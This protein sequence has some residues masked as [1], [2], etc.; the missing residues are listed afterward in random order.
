MMSDVMS[1]LW[2]N[3]FFGPV[4]QLIVQ[5]RVEEILSLDT[6]ALVHEN[7]ILQCRDR[8]FKL[9]TGKKIKKKRVKYDF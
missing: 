8:V 5:G 1:L 9:V 7:N 4:S 6:C 2:A 3:K